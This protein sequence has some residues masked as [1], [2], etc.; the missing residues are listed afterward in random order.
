MIEILLIRHGQTDW[1]VEKRIMGDRPIGL[2]EAGRKQIEILAQY[3]K[4]HSLDKIY[5][6]PHLR[7]QE[8]AKII[9]G[10]REVE[11]VEASSLREIEHGEWVGKTF[12]EIRALPNYVPYY[13]Q[14]H[15]P[16]GSTGESLEE[17]KKRGVEFVEKI[18]KDNKAGRFAL[19]SHADWIKC[20]LV[21]Y[22]K[23][24]L[25]QLAQFRIDN[26]SISYLHFDEK[27]ERVICVNHGIES[28]RLLG[29]K[30][31]L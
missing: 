1:N 3:L 26:G 14:P 29:V 9:A 2:N 25:T 5:T 11:L 22:M 7:A 24:P 20:V 21:H 15:L 23:M 19:V 16:M 10:E 4:G 6:S 12:S 30:E 13:H 18:R 17:V 28:A 31:F 27:Q 8:T